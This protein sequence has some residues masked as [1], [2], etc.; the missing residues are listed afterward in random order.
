MTRSALNTGSIYAV[1]P[2]RAAGEDLMLGLGRGALQALANHIRRAGEEPIAM[3]IVGRPQDLVRADIVGEHPE[4]A[5][6]R[7]ERDPAIALEQL[8]RPRLQP[9]ILKPLV[10]EMAVHAVETRRHPTAARL[11]EAEAQLRVAFDDAPPD[12]AEA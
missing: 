11:E 12:H 6:D 10:V 7:L 3:R 9:G 2:H 4:A 8:A 1:E 5:L